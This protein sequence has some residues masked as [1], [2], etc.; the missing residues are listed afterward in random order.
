MRIANKA[1]TLCKTLICALAFLIGMSF[2]NPAVA[3]KK[4]AK[5]P[6]AKPKPAPAAAAPKGMVRIPP[7]EFLFG[8]AQ[9]DAECYE[10]EK[11]AKRVRMTKGFYIDKFEVTQEA[12]REAMGATPSFFVNCGPKCPVENVS[13]DAASGYCEKLGKRL[14][15]EAEWEYAARGKSKTRYYWGD[16]PNGD[17]MWYKDNAQVDYEGGRDGMGTHPIGRK[18]PNSNGMYDVAGSVWEWTQD[19]WDPGWHKIMPAADPVNEGTECKGRVLRGGSWFL[20]ARMHRLS[21]R[22]GFY[23]ER[24]NYFTGFRCAKDLPAPK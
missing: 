4:T 22:N 11:P 6:A 13:W 10:Y 8:C 12:Y 21:Y 23:P 3:A 15:T 18:K 9:G 24:V 1:H 14:P 20:E 2:A 17:Y 5:K 7:G 16:K 19:C